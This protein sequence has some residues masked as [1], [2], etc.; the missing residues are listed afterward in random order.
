MKEKLWKIIKPFYELGAVCMGLA[1]TGLL[2]MGIFS[3]FKKDKPRYPRIEAI[4]TEAIHYEDSIYVISKKLDT[5]YYK[6]AEYEPE[7][8]RP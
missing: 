3:L 2:F 7:D 5:V 4:Q 1:I 8:K 6:A